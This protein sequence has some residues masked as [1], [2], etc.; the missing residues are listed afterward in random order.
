[1]DSFKADLIVAP[2]MICD[3]TIETIDGSE[4]ADEGD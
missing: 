4:L 2:P 1:M 3:S